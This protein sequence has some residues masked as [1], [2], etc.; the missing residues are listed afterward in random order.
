VTRH[1]C[2]R[3]TEIRKQPQGRA[4]T[5]NTPIGEYFG[6]SVFGGGDT[7]GDG[8]PDIIAG[9]PYSDFRCPNA[10]RAEVVDLHTPPSFTKVMI[11][12]VTWG[13]PDGLEITNFDTQSSDLAAWT[14]R[15]DDG[16]TQVSASL[17][18]T[19]APGGTILIK[20]PSGS[21]PEAPA[22][23]PVLSILPNLSTTSRPA[24]SRADPGPRIP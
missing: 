3:G 9:A 13:N 15:W 1:D 16:T 18:V 7:D 23:V 5:I 20:E 14:V 2:R 21:F 8:A 22:S 17:G 19:I 12:E 24:R 4:L 6:Y 10:G 11:T